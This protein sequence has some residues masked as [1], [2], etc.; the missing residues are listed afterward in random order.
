MSCKKG[1]FKENFLK[2]VFLDLSK[3]FVSRK[4]SRKFAAQII[5]DFGKGRGRNSSS[6]KKSQTHVRA[7]LQGLFEKSPLHPKNFCKPKSPISAGE[8]G[9]NTSSPT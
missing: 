9:S 2:K 1:F 8:G 5:C 3:T 7:G 4:S 6:L